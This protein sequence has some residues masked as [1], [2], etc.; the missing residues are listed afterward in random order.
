METKFNVGD[1]VIQPITAGKTQEWCIVE[2][3]E[4]AVV[5]SAPWNNSVNVQWEA[6]FSTLENWSVKK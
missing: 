3:K 1:K 4:N 6:P 2:I 5:L